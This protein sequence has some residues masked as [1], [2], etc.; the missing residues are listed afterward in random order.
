MRFNDWSNIETIAKIVQVPIKNCYKKREILTCVYQPSKYPHFSS[1]LF[2]PLPA[3][4]EPRNKSFKSPI[5]TSPAGSLLCFP[6]PFQ[7]PLFLLFMIFVQ[8]SFSQQTNR[9]DSLKTDS[10]NLKKPDSTKRNLHLK[11]SVTLTNKGISYIPNLS[12]GKPAILFDLSVAK[13]KLS[14]EPQLRFALDG[15]PW[16]FLFPVRCKIKSSGKFQVSA[17]INPLMNFKKITSIVNGISGTELVSRRYLGGEIRPS[18]YFTKNMSI[19]TQYLYFCGVSDHAVKNTH[20]VSFNA[21]FSNI[22]FGKKFFA[23]FNPQLYYLYQ[24]G[25]KGYYATAALTLVRRNFPFSIQT[26][27]NATIRSTITTSE[28][29]I[30]NASLIYT[31]TRTYTRK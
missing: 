25:K 8:Y 7:L 6:F 2:S 17:G 4:M 1:S 30:W 12:L 28:K 5:I 22:K 21:G 11:T 14:F 16:A 13:E 24:D 10:I 3:V 18:Y 31:F 23:R 9:T 29:F 15:E 27:M 26:I 19:G 20:F